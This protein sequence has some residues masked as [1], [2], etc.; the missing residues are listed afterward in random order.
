MDQVKIGKFIAEQRKLN[1]LTQQQLGDMLGVSNKTVS[2]WENGNYMP[3]IEMIQLIS[4]ALHISINEILTGRILSETEFRA[5]ADN[6]IVQIS[7]ESAFSFAEQKRL[8]I[9]KWRKEHIGL[10]IL[11]FLL[12]I[13]FIV[14]AIFSG[15]TWLLGCLGV[16]CFIEY[17]WQNNLMMIYVE[18]KLYE[19]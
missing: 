3:D 11:L 12:D 16:V 14:Y 19:K 18:N 13:A 17:G 2:R 4:K 6:N 5:E 7:R 9:Q 8:W 1:A 15:K 10:F